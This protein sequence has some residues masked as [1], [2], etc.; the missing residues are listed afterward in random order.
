M[1]TDPRVLLDDY[2]SQDRPYTVVARI[3]G[4]VRTAFPDGRPAPDPSGDEDTS[5]TV[6]E[7]DAGG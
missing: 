2:T 6:E 7:D 3:S 5:E 4:K 1:T